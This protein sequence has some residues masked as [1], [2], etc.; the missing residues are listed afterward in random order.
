[1]KQFVAIIAGWFIWAIG[2][3]VLYGMHGMHCGARGLPATALKPSM[4]IIHL[5]FSLG[6][7]GWWL[8]T[9]RTAF[10]VPASA[11]SDP[12]RHLVAAIARVS[13][14]GAL[15]A[16]LLFGIAVYFTSSCA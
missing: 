5:A 6:L 10:M 2:F 7:L 12:R 8:W 13:A 16:W 3:V 14:A 11:G 15:L 4:L 9:R 1:M